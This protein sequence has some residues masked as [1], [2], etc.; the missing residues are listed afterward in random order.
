MGYVG[1]GHN[2]KV[3]KLKSSVLTETSTKSL[4]NKIDKY[5]QEISFTNF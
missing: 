2:S 3:L 1:K 5:F 4:N